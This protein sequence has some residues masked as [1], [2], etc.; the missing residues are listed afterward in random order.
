MSLNLDNKKSDLPI[1]YVSMLRK[2]HITSIQQGYHTHTHTHTWRKKEKKSQ[3]IQALR[4][5][6]EMAR[7]LENSTKQRRQLAISSLN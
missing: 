7:K 5:N 4:A 3:S 1:H 2:L 6:I